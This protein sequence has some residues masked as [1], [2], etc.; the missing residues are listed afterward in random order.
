MISDDCLASASYVTYYNSKRCKTKRAK[1]VQNY[2]TV[3]INAH[4]RA[5]F[6]L[7]LFFFV[8]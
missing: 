4:K 3:L 6:V 1:H 7:F 8:F 2:K 5:H